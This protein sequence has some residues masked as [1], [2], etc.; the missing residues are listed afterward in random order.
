MHYLWG[1]WNIHLLQPSDISTLCCQAFGLGLRLHH[2]LSWTTSWET[3]DVGLLNLRDHSKKSAIN[4][5]VCVCILLVLSLWRLKYNYKRTLILN[6]RK[7]TLK[8]KSH[9]R[10]PG[11]FC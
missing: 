8:K 10:N 9:D 3:A 1:S 11:D 5:S 2:Q 7:H 6:A 4:S